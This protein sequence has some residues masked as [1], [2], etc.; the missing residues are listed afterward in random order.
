MPEDLSRNVFTNIKLA[1]ASIIDDKISPFVHL[2]IEIFNVY[3]GY[4]PY[5]TPWTLLLLGERN[6]CNV[7]GICTCI[8]TMFEFLAT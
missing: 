7:G 1:Y 8:T 2:F 3:F 5:G 4:V 6:I